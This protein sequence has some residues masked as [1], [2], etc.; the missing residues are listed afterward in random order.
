VLL[1]RLRL[2]NNPLEREPN[3]RYQLLQHFPSLKTLDEV[4]LP[5]GAAK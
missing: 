5:E 2:K 1:K 3:Y 4:V